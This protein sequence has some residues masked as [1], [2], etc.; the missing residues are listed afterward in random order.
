MCVNVPMTSHLAYD[1][2]AAQ[3]VLIHDCDD[4]GGLS[5]DVSGD[6]EGEG[7]IKYWIQ[8]PLHHH[9]LLLLHSFIFVHQPHF[10][11]GV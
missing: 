4:D 7:L 9:R 1:I 5:E 8:T 10:D 6:I 11:V 2:I 3:S